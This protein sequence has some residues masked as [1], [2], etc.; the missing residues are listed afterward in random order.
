MDWGITNISLMPSFSTIGEPSFDVPIRERRRQLVV[1][2]R[3]WQRQLAYSEG[4]AALANACTQIAAE[5]I[6]DIG[7]PIPGDERS[8][9]GG[10]PLV[11]CGSLPAAEVSGWMHSS[12][13]SFLFYPDALLTKSTIY[14]A[15]CA[16]GTIPFVAS[17]C[18]E[19][20]R[21]TELYKGKDY[22]PLQA[23]SPKLD[24]TE[25]QE[26]STTVYE[27]YQ[28]RNSAASAKQIASIMLALPK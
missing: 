16:H 23:G 4:A 14:A 12:L 21:E 1:F 17:N 20:L 26:I 2:G 19:S 3:P 11:R 28:D 24:P 22:I 6:I 9:V 27:R 5:R 18:E 25:F 15:T 13:A 7:D 10:V 8:D